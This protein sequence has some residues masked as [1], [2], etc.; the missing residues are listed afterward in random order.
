MQ[1]KNINRKD[2]LQATKYLISM[3]PKEALAEYIVELQDTIEYLK[4]GKK[5]A[6]YKATNTASMFDFRK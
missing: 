3:L 5:P 4:S 2:K 1:K 6:S